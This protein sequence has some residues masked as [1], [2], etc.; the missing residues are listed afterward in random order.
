MENQAF[1]PQKVLVIFIF[2][3]PEVIP[4][5]NWIMQLRAIERGAVPPTCDEELINSDKNKNQRFTH[6]NDGTSDQIRGFFLTRKN[7]NFLS[8]KRKVLSSISH[9]ERGRRWWRR[10]QNAP[11]P[12]YANVGSRILQ[13]IPKIK[14]IKKVKEVQQTDELDDDNQSQMDND[15]Q[16][17]SMISDI[18]S[19]LS[20]QSEQT[21]QSF[22]QE[23]LQRKSN[24]GLISE[25]LPETPE[26]GL[27][28][29][30]IDPHEASLRAQ[31]ALEMIPELEEPDLSD[32]ESTS[33]DCSTDDSGE[34]KLDKEEISVQKKENK[35][36]KKK[37]RTIR[38]KKHFDNGPNA[39]DVNQRRTVRMQPEDFP[40]WVGF[41]NQPA[42]ILLDINKCNSTIQQ[43]QD[44]PI[45]AVGTELYPMFAPHAEMYALPPPPQLKS[46]LLK[47]DTSA[48]Q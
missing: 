45:D 22:F 7:E 23:S 13:L 34:E 31:K 28:G 44:N 43:Q 14:K 12:L 46:C 16:L 9:S 30:S 17:Q 2:D 4:G 18:D 32:L 1:I 27:S 3:E 47:L 19:Q 11:I 48:G 42:D 25:G 5:Q 37:N 26:I 15:S 33:F 39:L 29:E 41:I 40:V 36:E 10:H 8:M 38:K 35:K 20:E 24:S 6:V 21:I